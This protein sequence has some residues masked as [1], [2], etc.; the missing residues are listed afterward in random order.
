MPTELRTHDAAAMRRALDL[1]RLG[2][3]GGPNPQVGC[4]LIGPSGDV[5]AEGVH[6][7]AGTPHAEVDALST[8]PH[9]AAAGATA[10]VT[11]EPCDH[12]GRTGPCSIAL[13][14]AGIARVVVAQPDPNPVA[15]GGAQRLRSAGVTVETGVLADEAS[16]LNERWATAVARGRPWV[17]V[18]WASSLDGR[19]AAPDGTSRWIT[20]PVARADV[21]RRRA[22]HGAILVGTGTALADDPVLTA[23][24]A[25]GPLPHQPRPV[26]VG[27]RDLPEGAALHG[28]PDLLRIREHDPSAVLDA[29][30]AAGLTSVLVEGGPTVASA[31]LAAG[32]VDEL[33]VY[34]APTLL[35][36]DRLATG[37]LGVPTIAARHRLAVRATVA[38]GADLLVV[39]RPAP[40]GA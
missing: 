22:E 30:T 1:A 39:A 34:L 20:G 16:A 2:P 21:H 12:V 27:H 19:I 40:E 3:P 33:L 25:D 8:V 11:L 9:G 36:G 6:R 13:L 5:L 18:K 15:A 37:D 32:L 28:R 4:V 7:G 23:R 24:G 29:L 35:G 26:V 17:T 31:F 10:V 14:G 38:L